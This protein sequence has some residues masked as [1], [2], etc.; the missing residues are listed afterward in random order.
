MVPSD[1][2]RDHPLPPADDGN[3]R[4]G[5]LLRAARA[6][7]SPADGHRRTVRRDLPR[8]DI[9]RASGPRFRARGAV[10]IVLA[11]VAPIAGP[12]MAT[13]LRSPLPRER[14]PR[15]GG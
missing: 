6:A 2:R 13:M 11:S 14:V 12:S 7:L 8:T 10:E 15:S 3:A 5:R 9:S 4:C 1:G